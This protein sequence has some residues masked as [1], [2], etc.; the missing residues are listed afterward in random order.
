[1]DPLLARCPVEAESHV[2]YRKQPL[3]YRSKPLQVGRLEHCIAQ[4]DCVISPFAPVHAMYEPAEQVT[5]GTARKLNG[6]AG[7]GGA[8]GAKY[9][10]YVDVDAR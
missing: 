8:D 3:E 7:G 1:V 6:G 4:S 2:L 10:V 9:R 5:P